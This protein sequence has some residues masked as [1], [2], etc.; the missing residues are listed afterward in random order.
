MFILNHSI[1]DC[2]AAYQ[3]LLHI[4]SAAHVNAYQLVNINMDANDF[5]LLIRSKLVF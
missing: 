4:T 3:L 2:K 1:A 5:I